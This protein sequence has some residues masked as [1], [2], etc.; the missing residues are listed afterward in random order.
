M[1]DSP[2][3]E[4]CPPAGIPA[5]EHAPDHHE[6]EERKEFTDTTLSPP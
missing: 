5:L 3:Q 1:S 2:H 4:A 6:R